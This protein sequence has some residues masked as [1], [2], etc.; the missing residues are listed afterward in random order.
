MI[1]RL[2]VL[3]IVFF[4][5]AFVA[6]AQL[7]TDKI[8]LYG[9]YSFLHFSDNGSFNQNGWELQGQYKLFPF[10]GA[11]ADFSGDYGN[12]VSTH[13][14]LFGP[15]VS[16]PAR[17]SPFAHVLIGAAHVGSNFVIG[18]Q[19]PTFVSASDTSFAT[20]VGG[21]IDTRLI[22]GIYWRIF[23]ADW[24]HSSAFSGNQ[25]NVRVSTG[26]VVHF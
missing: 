4:A 5:A 3:A 7:D 13:Y 18:T 16:W 11:V 25:N 1:R 24:I 19:P 15:E 8:E 17:V 9:G 20:A 12:G 21:G 23:Q 22:H 14:F 26:I 2:S 10:L 6:Q